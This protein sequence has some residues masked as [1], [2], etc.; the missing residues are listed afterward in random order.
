MLLHYAITIN[1]ITYVPTL[2]DRDAKIVWEM[3]DSGYMYNEHLTGK[4]TLNRSGNETLYDII[5]A[6]D[7]CDYAFIGL[8]D[9]DDAE[10]VLSIFYLIDC[11]I[12]SD[13]CQIVI[14]PKD[15]SQYHCFQANLDADYNI[16]NSNIQT[17]VIKYTGYNNFELKTC[18]D[19]N[20][21][22]N[23]YYLFGKWRDIANS[24]EFPDE[25]AK[26][27]DMVNDLMQNSSSDGWT[28][29][30]QIMNSLGGTPFVN[31]DITTVWFREVKL[32]PNINGTATS[33]PVGGGFDWINLGIVL[34]NGQE[35]FHWV[36]SVSNLKIE[37]TSESSRSVVFS[38]TDYD[39]KVGLLS[40]SYGRTISRAR[41]LNDVI[42][43][44][45]KECN[46]SYESEF[47]TNPT[48]PISGKDLSNLMIVQKSDCI[49][50]G[51]P[52]VEPTDAATLGIITFNSLLD[53]LKSMFQ[54]YWYIDDNDTLHI[55]HKNYFS[56]NL[57]YATRSFDSNVDL[58]INVIYPLA[59]QGSNNWT[60]DTE[61]PYREKFKFLEAWNIDFIGADIVYD[62]CLR[63]GTTENHEAT[64][65]TTDIDSTYLDNEASKDGFCLFHC[66]SN[67]Y[68]SITSG[69][70]TTNYYYVLKETGELSGMD[71]FNAHL[72]WA[73]LHNYY[74]K[75]DRPVPTG[76]MNNKQTTFTTTRKLKRQTPI[77]FPFCP[78]NFNPNRLIRTRMA[79]DGE[80]KSAEYSLKTGNIK[81]EL[82]YE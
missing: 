12:N 71:S 70:V 3:G 15:Y 5:A 14:N 16:I 44:M 39:G 56:N 36:R 48:N 27:P 37:R 43:E 19:Y 28:F 10:V 63:K 51:S 62:T 80:V 78:Q 57:S 74:W 38:V 1:N 32:V 7:V 79:T 30:S 72:S 8:Y 2:V 31:F 49:M 77:S 50:S 53:N 22:T 81:V 40:T 73:N 24:D 52:P 25:R 20:R 47:F 41:K 18:Y 42:T 13:K 68:L 76:L 23:S 29:Y 45:A 46:L 33:P 26:C 58:D 17:N 6:W 60:F 9:Q 66:D 69:G 65:F 21:S 61:Y 4:F 82:L 11:E 55:E 75:Y 35:Y 64:L 59:L 67:S 34:R 54:V